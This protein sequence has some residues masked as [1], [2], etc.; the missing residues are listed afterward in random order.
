MVPR[1]GLAGAVSLRSMPTLATM[2]LSRRWGTRVPWRMRTGVPWRA[3]GLR[4]GAC[5]R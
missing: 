4:V 3:W 5:Y 2:E 1:L